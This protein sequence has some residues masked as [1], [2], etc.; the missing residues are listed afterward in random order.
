MVSPTQT[1]QEKK[2]VKILRRSEDEKRM[3]SVTLATENWT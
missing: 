3:L 2:K 1:H